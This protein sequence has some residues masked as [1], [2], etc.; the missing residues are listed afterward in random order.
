MVAE[1]VKS[2]HVDPKAGGRE[3]PQRM[4]RMTQ[5]FETSKP[6]PSDIPSPTRPHQPGTKY[7]NQ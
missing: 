5:P 6:A 7:L 2:S 3:T 4:T 1:I